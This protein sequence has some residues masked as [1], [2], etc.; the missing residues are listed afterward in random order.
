M[1]D[2]LVVEDNLVNRELLREIL[3]SR[4][5]SVIEAGDGQEA[6]QVLREKSPE[7]AIIDIQMPKITGYGLIKLIREDPVISHTKCLALTAY[8]MSGDHER[9]LQAGFDGYLTKPFETNELI[10]AIH[11]L[12]GVH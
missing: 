5:Y 7:L 11:H 9:V 10:A 3:E 1:K 12:L 2:I 8:A 4:D 6:L